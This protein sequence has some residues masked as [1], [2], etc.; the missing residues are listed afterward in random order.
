[1]ELALFLATCKWFE[2]R[3]NR[4]LQQLAGQPFHRLPG[5]KVIVNTVEE[6]K[7]R[8]KERVKRTG[9]RPGSGEKERGTV[10]GLGLRLGLGLGLGFPMGSVRV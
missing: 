10:L 9:K 6:G 3:K 1:M 4:D 2:E 5:T 8:G 7:E